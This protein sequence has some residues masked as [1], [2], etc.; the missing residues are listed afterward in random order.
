MFLKNYIFS[1]VI[2]FCHL[3][4][5]KLNVKR[6]S[7]LPHNWKKTQNFINT[8]WSNIGKIWNLIARKIYTFIVFCFVCV[9]LSF[10]STSNQGHMEAGPHIKLTVEVLVE[11]GIKPDNPWFTWQMTYPLHHSIIAI[12]PVCVIPMANSDSIDI[13]SKCRTNSD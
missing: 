7:V 3:C 8:E 6:N 2:C 11:Q 4:I 9:C 13:V 5:S 10:T 12:Q 1:H